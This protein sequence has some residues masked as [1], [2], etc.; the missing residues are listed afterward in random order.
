V[1]HGFWLLETHDRKQEMV[2]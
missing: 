2:L 1:A